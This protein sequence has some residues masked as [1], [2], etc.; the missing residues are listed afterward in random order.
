MAKVEKSDVINDVLIVTPDVFGDERGM[1]VET[2]RK[3]WLPEG[4]PEMVQGN[5]A[6]RKKGSLV[7]M[8]YH[9]QQEDFWY[10]PF[11]KALV[12]LHDLREGSSTNGK[13]LMVEIGDENHEGVYIPRGIAHG[14]LALTDMT[15]TYLVDNY[16]NGSDELGV[17]YN[18]P[19]LAF[20]WPLDDLTVSDRDKSNPLRKDIPENLR[21]VAKS[22]YD[23]APSS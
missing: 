14:F 11:G 15:I 6:T 10:V 5:R 17:L 12:A 9:L 20:D 4:A 7:G 2:F 1:F 13:S 23:V 3:E 18:D 22:L 19:E 8:H 16:Y 21:P